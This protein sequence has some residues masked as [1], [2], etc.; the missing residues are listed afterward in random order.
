MQMPHVIHDVF[1]GPMDAMAGQG[2]IP[3]PQKLRWGWSNLRY[4][5]WSILGCHN[6]P[7]PSVLINGKTA[8]GKPLH[9]V[10][11]INIEDQQL[12]IITAYEPDPNLW[13][14]DYKRRI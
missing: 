3:D 8:K 2:Q 9:V 5:T 7:L 4:H 6:D 11:A 13:S 1:G 14:E 12:I 10:A